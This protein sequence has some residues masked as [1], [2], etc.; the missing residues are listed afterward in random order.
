MTYLFLAY[1]FLDESGDLG[2]NFNNKKTSRFFIISIISTE[3]K[4]P[5]EKATSSIHRNLRKKYKIRSGILHA[6]REEP[7]TRVRYLRKISEKD[8][9]IIAIYIDKEKLFSRLHSQNLYIYNQVTN[10]L[11]DRIQSKGIINKKE[12]IELIVSR[13]ETSRFLNLN[14]INYIKN[15]QKLNNNLQVK[16]KIK[17][18]ADEKSLQVA[19]VVSWSIFRKYEHNDDFYYTIIK[20]LIIEE[21]S[22]FP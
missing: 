7:I 1:L 17:T 13:R 22:L 19:D 20:H 4:K 10:I 2:F 12:G 6:H 8:I 21:N 16:I 9:N 18:P 5:L 15:Q 3:N 11:L 14:F